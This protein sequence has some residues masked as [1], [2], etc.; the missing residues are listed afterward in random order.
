LGFFSS[1]DFE[2][3]RLSKK[4]GLAQFEFTK[5]F[6]NLVALSAKDRTQVSALNSLF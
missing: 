1:Q 5:E 3:T 2:V 4:F 6:V